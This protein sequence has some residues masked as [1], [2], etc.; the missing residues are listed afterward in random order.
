MPAPLTVEAKIRMNSSRRF[1]FGPGKAD[2]L[3]RIEA[4]G[5]I[6]EAAKTMVMSYMRAWQIVK[7][8]DGAFAEPLVLK[9]RGGK[10]KGGAT[11][12]ETGREVLRLYRDMESSAQSACEK[13]S[14]RLAALLK[15]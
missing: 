15:S 13:S 12:S 7:S 3:A 9:S 1:A 4:T 10:A 5:S 2:L 8:L 14:A 11:L 6:S